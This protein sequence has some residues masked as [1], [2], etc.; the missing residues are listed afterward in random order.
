MRAES[1]GSRPYRTR[2]QRHC[3]NHCSP[4]PYSPR[5]PRPKLS[6]RNHRKLMFPGVLEK[7]ARICRKLAI[8]GTAH[9]LVW[10]GGLRKSI[11]TGSGPITRRRC[12]F[13]LADV[14]CPDPSQVLS[15]MT[16]ELKVDGEV[17]FLSDRGEQPDRFAI[18][19]VE[20]ILSPLIVP[21][22]NLRSSDENV[23]NP[24][25]ETRGSRS[26]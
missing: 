16:P 6:G 8:S 22:E 10:G 18:V 13:R 3:A 25:T 26:R 9:A 24:N 23:L 5:K 21:T 1:P 7:S 11:M 14:L 17:V 12:S 2:P 19:S 15:Q 4:A 20:G